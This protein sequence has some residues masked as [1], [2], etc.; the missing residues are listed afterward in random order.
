VPGSSVTQI[1]IKDKGQVATQGLVFRYVSEW[2]DPRTWGDF[3]PVEGDS[4]HIPSG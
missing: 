3:I 1:K 2:A 4:V